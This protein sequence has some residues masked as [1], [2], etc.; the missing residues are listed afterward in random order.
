MAKDLERT[1]YSEKDRSA[2]SF[3]INSSTYISQTSQTGLE[4][5]TISDAIK[6]VPGFLDRYYF[7]NI[8]FDQDEITSRMAAMNNPVGLF[9][10][11]LKGA[12]IVLPCQLSVYMDELKKDQYV[13]SVIVVEDDASVQLISGC[14]GNIASGKSAHYSVEEIYIGNNCQFTQTMLHNWQSPDIEVSMHSAT[15][16]GK[17]S[18]YVNTYISLHPPKTLNSRPV[19]S[20]NGRNSSAILKSVVLCK[21]H[22][23][24]DVGGEVV[25]RG[26]NS[27]AQ[28]LHRGICAG[29][30]LL[31]GGMVRGYNRCKG[32]VDCAGMIL[33]TD[34]GGEIESVPGISAV[35]SEA[36]LSHEASIGRIA[37]QQVEYLMSRSVD[38][39]TAISLMIGGFIGDDIMNLPFSLKKEV[40]SIASIAG[41]QEQT[42][43]S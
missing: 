21:D 9:I 18:T 22:S 7:R 43:R 30:S 17:N 27:N 40:D 13:H 4:I 29:G 10:H 34:H 37:P 33:D 11:V 8:R 24:L 32:H 3:I 31:Q 28:L 41:H 36:Q 35:N 15:V 39:Q 14:A 23:D 2:K 38:E 42:K 12:R 25:L 26:A 16:V 20:L 19:V 1:G 6:N 5:M